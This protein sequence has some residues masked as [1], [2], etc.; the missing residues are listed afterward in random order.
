MAS[1]HMPCGIEIPQVFFDGPVDMEHI[2]K[3]VTTA[4]TLGYDS[5]WLQERI[6]GGF[7]VLEPVTLLSYV[8]ALTTRP[9]LGTS[10]ILLTLRNPIQLAKSLSTLDCM[11]GGRLTFGIGLGGGH[12]RSQEEVFGYSREKRVRR[13]S[14]AVEVIKLLWTEPRASFQGSFWHFENVGM[15]PKPL[16]KPHP[17]I[18]FGGHHE[19]ALKRAVAYGNGWMGAGSSSSSAFFRESAMIRRFLDEAKRDPATFGI[20][21]RVYLAIDNDRG[22]AERRL[23]E[24]FEKR[25][26]N[27]DLGP[28]VCIWGGRE[29]CT[30]KIQ[31]IVRAG[32]Q[33]IVFNPM[34]D[35]R[36]HLEICAKEIMPHLKK[37]EG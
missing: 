20:A 11:S 18:W 30:E 22:R 4:E 34:F 2:R 25:Y 31:E 28:R 27:A 8:A 33:Q 13:F 19:N 37:H 26:K 3:F 10:V 16:Q 35:E 9:R 1:D 23:R 5:L 36:E 24:W 7:A 21:K 12:L 29:E 6:I 14:E 15:E 32:A 17:P